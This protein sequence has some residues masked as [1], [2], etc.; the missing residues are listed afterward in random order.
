MEFCAIFLQKDS[1]TNRLG[2]EE[3]RY[4]VTERERAMNGKALEFVRAQI[5]R[6]A[7]QTAANNYKGKYTAS[8]APPLLF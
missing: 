3:G 2:F 4:P 8:S 5:Y 6:G 1:E 7:K